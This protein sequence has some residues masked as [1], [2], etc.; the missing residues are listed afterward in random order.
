MGKLR[1]DIKERFEK[2]EE[3]FRNDLQKDI[4]QFE[5]N[6]KKSLAYLKRTNTDRGFDFD[7]SINTDSGIDKIGLLA[8]MGGL[9]FGIFGLLGAGAANFWNPAGWAAIGLGLLGI[10]KSIWS[11]FS[12]SYKKSQQK[13]QW[14]R[15]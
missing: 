13:K 14:I 11:F 15:V 4:R 9:G 3:Q 10:V 2:N 8:S 7:F 1:K 5:Y 6:T 12:S